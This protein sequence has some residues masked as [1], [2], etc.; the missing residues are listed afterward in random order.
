VKGKSTKQFL[1]EQGLNDLRPRLRCISCGQTVAQILRSDKNGRYH[2]EE[3][4]WLDVCGDRVTAIDKAKEG[5]ICGPCLEYEEAEPKA[6]VIL[7]ADEKFIFHIGQYAIVETGD[8]EI[9]RDLFEEVVKPYAMSLSWKPT[10][11]WRGAYI[12]RF[13]DGWAK[14]IDDWFGTIDGHNCD[15]GDLGKFYDLYEV[16]K[17]VPEFPLLVSFP[18]T[19]NV[20][21]C[22]IECFTRA[23]D[24]AKF[25]SWLGV[26]R[27]EIEY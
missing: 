17:D 27:L 13:K 26:E 24:I 2:I 6:V 11:A 5:W 9:P 7:H 25:K 21:A 12:G 14:V 4:E 16:R 8:D 1:E 10:D 23:E 20:C 19:S 3:G 18:R 15:R 22:G